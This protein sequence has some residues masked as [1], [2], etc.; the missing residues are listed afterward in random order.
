M[1]RISGGK[2]SLNEASMGMREKWSEDAEMSP[3]AAFGG[4]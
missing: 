3:R 4:C 2:R 1:G